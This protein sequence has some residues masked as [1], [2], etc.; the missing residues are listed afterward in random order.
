MHVEIAGILLISKRSKPF[1]AKGEWE[2]FKIQQSSNSPGMS[3]QEKR[4]K[5]LNF[6]LLEADSYF[7]FLIDSPHRPI[8]SICNMFDN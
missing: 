3:Q 8:D 2:D 1:V 6:Q 5:L 4:R 7:Q